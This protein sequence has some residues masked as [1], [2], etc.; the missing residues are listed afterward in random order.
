MAPRCVRWADKFRQKMGDDERLTG[1]V[2][3]HRGMRGR[4]R[5]LFTLITIENIA[6]SA[7]S[8]SAGALF[9]MK[10]KRLPVAGARIGIH[11]HDA[12]ART[13]APRSASG[14]HARLRCAAGG[15]DRIA[16]F[17]A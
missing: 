15:P 16:R 4:P 1:F 3:W 12:I 7:F 9:D 13:R 2:G 8:T 10:L 17:R 11:A 6:A 14:C 5:P